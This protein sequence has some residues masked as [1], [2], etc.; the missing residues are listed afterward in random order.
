MNLSDAAGPQGQQHQR[1]SKR[2]ILSHSHGQGGDRNANESQSVARISSLLTPW[3][4][5]PILVPRRM[6][7]VNKIN[8]SLQVC[9]KH[10]EKTLKMHSAAIPLQK[11]ANRPPHRTA[12]HTSFPIGTFNILPHKSNR[13]RCDYWGCRV[14]SST[15]SSRHHSNT[16]TQLSWNEKQ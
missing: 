8:R 11:P 9:P 15:G 5:V 10:L 1:D 14:Q 13:G 7:A 6:A 16:A 4:T 12:H 2:Y 3:P